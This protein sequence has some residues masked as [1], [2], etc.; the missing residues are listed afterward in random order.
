MIAAPGVYTM[1]MEAYQADP[2][3]TPSISS[4]LLHTMETK[5]D[6]HA[7]HFHPRLGKGQ[8][9]ETDTLNYGAACHDMLLEGSGKLVV[10]DAKDWRTKAAQEARDAAKAEGKLPVLTHQAAK[11]QT[12][13]QRAGEAILAATDFD[14]QDWLAG[15]SEQTLCWQEGGVWHRARVDRLSPDRRVLFDYKST[16]GSANPAAWQ[17]QVWG[18]GY[19]LQAVHY[20]AGNAATGGAVTAAWVWLVQEC[21]EPFACSWVSPSPQTLEY[22]RARRARLIA[23]WREC[24]A[25]GEWAGYPQK[26]AYID[27]PA[28]AV[29]AWEETALMDEAAQLEPMT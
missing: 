4:G 7:Y 18:L 19:D 16:K 10:I 9:E 20:L 8:R 23:R 25:T 28:Y 15:A 21:A 11:L 3:P 26:I 1:S 29:A 13:Y 17:R 2:C 12:M 14:P 24:L 5:S 27:P 22:A 6:A